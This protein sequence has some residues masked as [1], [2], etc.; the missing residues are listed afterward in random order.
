MKARS[1]VVMACCVGAMAL[2]F[3]Q[4]FSQT[5]SVADAK[6]PNIPGVVAGG[7]KV[8]LIGASF[9]GASGTVPAPDGS[10][11]LSNR[12]VNKIIKIA[13]DGTISTYRDKVDLPNGIAIDHQGRL[14]A[15][16]WTR[17][18]QI[19]ALGEKTIVLAN[20]FE[21]RSFG[22]VNDLV[23][24]MKGGVY[25]TDH[26]DAVVYFVG[27]SGQVIK[28]DD[29][30]VR[31]NGITLS[32]DGKVLYVSD[33]NGPAVIAYDVQPD[34]SVRNRRAFAMLD[35]VRKTEN[36]VASGADGITIDA[37][38]RLYVTANSAVQVFSPQGQPLGTIR[39]PKGRMQ[40]V[41]F[42]GSDGKTLYVTG[43]NIVYKIAMQ[44]EGFKG[45]PK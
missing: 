9:E 3:G 4:A 37:A 17:P 33:T 11:L 19:G 7:T 25:F 39:V 13:A 5:Q 16:Q 6:T 18:P 38:G 1:E 23:V 36:G 22:G 32:P 21:R 30:M 44:A 42:A 43:D 41:A 28:I 27:P 35:G 15:A 10:L 26:V 12:D 34:G 45:R 14:V 31:P 8:E 24:D 2:G 20:K 29:T 40:S